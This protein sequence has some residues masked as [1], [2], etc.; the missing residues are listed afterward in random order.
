MNQTE[1]LSLPQWEADDRIMRTDFNEAFQKLDA[2]VGTLGT[3]KVSAS[4]LDALSARVSALEGSSLT[5]LKDVTVSA[6]C[7]GYSLDLSDINWAQ[8]QKVHIDFYVGGSEGNEVAAIANNNASIC[9]CYTF[10]G[11]SGGRFLRLGVTPGGVS[12]HGRATLFVQQMPE[13]SVRGMYDL[14]RAFFAAVPYSQLTSLDLFITDD[15]SRVIPGSVLAGS[16]MVVY[17]EK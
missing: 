12:Y 1:N 8:W 16:R 4:A 11:M 6:S 14:T 7:T 5:L 9:S 2:A 17:G 3:D 15:G 13:M 10:G